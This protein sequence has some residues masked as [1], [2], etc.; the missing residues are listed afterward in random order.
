M[1]QYISE[2]D[3]AAIMR[4]LMAD[5]KKKIAELEQQ[6]VAGQNWHLLYT[7]RG[8]E[9]GECG[10]YIGELEAA[11]RAVLYALV[12]NAI[13]TGN[14]VWMQPPHCPDAIHESAVERLQAALGIDDLD[15]FLRAIRE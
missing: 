15:S 3:C 4:Q 5:D 2:G 7:E 8:R 12:V 14:V 9:L 1:S 6:V 11:G 10:E 13:E